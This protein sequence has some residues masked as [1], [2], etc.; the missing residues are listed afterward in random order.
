MTV[1]DPLPPPVPANI[2]RVIV[3]IVGEFSVL[4]DEG[5]PEIQGNPTSNPDNVGHQ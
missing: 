4:Q 1:A 3:L 2:E 5:A